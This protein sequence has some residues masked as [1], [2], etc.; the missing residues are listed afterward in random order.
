[1]NQEKDLFGL[2]EQIITNYRDGQGAAGLFRQLNELSAEWEHLGL[3]CAIPKHGRRNRLADDPID[4]G[5]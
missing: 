5:F 2:I 4:P 3:P 1:M